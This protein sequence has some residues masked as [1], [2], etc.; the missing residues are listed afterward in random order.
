MYDCG[1]LRLQLLINVTSLLLWKNLSDLEFTTPVCKDES[2]TCKYSK[3]MCFKNKDYTS[4]CAKTCGICGGEISTLA[5]PGGSSTSAPSPPPPPPA[6][7]KDKN[8]R[9]SRYL[10]YCNDSDMKKICKKTCGYC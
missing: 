5:P 9:C 3:W 10:K 6:S 1:K 2:H 8:R 7:C 4:K